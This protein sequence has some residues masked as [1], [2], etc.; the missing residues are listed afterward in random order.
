MKLDFFQKFLFSSILFLIP[1]QLGKHFWTNFAFFYGIK[2]DYLS[3]T[4]YLTDIFIVLFI[5]TTIIKKRKNLFTKPK[6]SPMLMF[7]LVF[8]IFSL[9]SVIFSK[10]LGASLYYLLRLLEFFLF[11]ASLV[12]YYK[13]NINLL[14]PLI[15]GAVVENILV[16]TQFIL[17]HSV[18]F[19]ILGEREFSVNTPG[20]AKMIINGDEY[21]R[22]YG[23]FPHPNVLAGYLLITILLSLVLIKK[24][25]KIKYVTVL[26]MLALLL[27]FSR[28]SLFLLLINVLIIIWYTK[29]KKHFLKLLV[30]L[31]T[32][33]AVL[34]QRIY[35]LTIYDFSSLQRRIE[36]IKSSVEI[37]V[38][39]PIFG[40]GLGASIP[41]V[42][43]ISHL[44]GSTR[45]IEPIHNIPLLLASEIG[46]IG[47]VSFFL[48]LLLV[49]RHEIKR[50]SI[51]ALI[52]GNIIFI[53]LFDHYFLTLQQG[54][55]LLTLAISL[56]LSKKYV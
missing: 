26:M 42:A 41:E 38:K 5:T 34:T 19:W 21:L 53:C 23:T 4:I 39:N 37:I 9:L 32:I 35:Q 6:P 11:G 8:L 15:Y 44:S 27:S 52:L 30:I 29:L 10:N 49:T 45:F 17:Q 7:F 46:I 55:L 18:G 40:V 54:Q 12:G 28:I 2:I 13:G 1:F 47:A 20:I 22:S 51:F 14:F 48:F 56:S 50:K 31:L 36:L 43:Q 3:P 24:M 25:P 16:V 33:A